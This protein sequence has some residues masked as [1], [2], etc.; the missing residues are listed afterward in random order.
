M[1]TEEGFLY[2]PGQ[3]V[4]LCQILCCLLSNECHPGHVL[5]RDFDLGRGRHEPLRGLWDLSGAGTVDL[6]LQNVDPFA[7]RLL[8]FRNERGHVP[9]IT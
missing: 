6:G 2:I 5:G 9:E 3:I 8:R 1:V 7:Y 4:S